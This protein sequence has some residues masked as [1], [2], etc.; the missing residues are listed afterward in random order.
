MVRALR[1]EM[2]QL[3]EQREA[4]FLLGMLG[5]DRFALGQ[6]VGIDVAT[7]MGQREVEV[8]VVDAASGVVQLI[9]W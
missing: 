1:R 9:G 2:A 5:D 7:L 3:R 4:Y 6:Q 8:D